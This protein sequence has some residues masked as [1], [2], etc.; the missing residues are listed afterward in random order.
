MKFCFDRC[1]FWVW[2]G[3]LPL[4]TFSI[5]SFFDRA[6]S[7]RTDTFGAS[8]LGRV[9]VH[10]VC[11]SN[12]TSPIISNSIILSKFLSASALGLDGPWAPGPTELLTRY[13]EFL[14]D[15]WALPHMREQ[16]RH[17]DVDLGYRITARFMRRREMSVNVLSLTKSFIGGCV[18]TPK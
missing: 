8:F 17:W 14:T 5:I 13:A 11:I 3:I 6:S 4:P 18:W 16:V 9:G 2:A 7:Y 10:C 1:D 15:L 12:R